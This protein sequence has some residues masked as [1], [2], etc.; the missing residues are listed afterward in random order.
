MDLIFKSSYH[1]HFL[2]DFKKKIFT[3]HV[4]E[5]C[6]WAFLDIIF[7]ISLTTFNPPFKQ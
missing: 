4:K 3:M 2:M 1:I 5:L 7:I 6:N